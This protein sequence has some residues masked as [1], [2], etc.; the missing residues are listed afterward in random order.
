MRYIFVFIFTI[1][2]LFGNEI[3]VTTLEK[4]ENIIQDVFY[5]EDLTN[6]KSIQEIFLSKEKFQE[7]KNSNLGIKKHTV[8]SYCTIKND[9]DTTTHLVLSNP[10]AGMDSIEVF[11][12]Q[13]GKLLKTIQLG[14]TIDQSQREIIHRKSVFRIELVPYKSIEIYAKSKNFGA[15]DIGWDIVTPKEFLESSLFDTLFYGLMGGLFLAQFLYVLKIYF[16]FR[17]ISLL[18][19]IGVTFF[20][21][22]AQYSIAGIFYQLNIG[23]PVYLNTFFAFG[24]PTIGVGLLAFFPV[25]FFELKKYHKYLAHILCFIGWIMIGIGASTLIYPWY[26]NIL[27]I[28]GNT[29]PITL[30]LTLTLIYT[31]FVVYREK[32]LGATYY[33]LGMSIF[34]VALFYFVLGLLGKVKIDDLFYYSLTLGTMFEIVFMVFTIFTKISQLK[35]EKERIEKI[36]NDYTNLLVVGQSMINITHQWKT[37]INHIHYAL[38][39]IEFA[40]EFNDAK[41]ETILQ[42]NIQKIRNGTEMMLETSSNFL[43]LYANSTIKK[44]S[45]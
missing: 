19:Y 26:E 18:I 38:N 24:T 22:L 44:R 34:G 33:F 42:S 37:P 31:G 39:Q 12:F 3:L 30:A 15:L 45:I 1:I 6:Q 9:T 7:A 8:W 13:D 14:D 16:T 4:R 29:L 28:A 25:Y 23:I 36:H 41:F 2:H 11:L 35:N 20:S 21:F 5:F 10:R 43:D 32:F 40:K 27:Y 17:E